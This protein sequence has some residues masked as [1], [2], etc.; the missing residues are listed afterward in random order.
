MTGGQP[1]RGQAGQTRPL[2]LWPTERP[3]PSALTSD[4][5]QLNEVALR[6]FRGQLADSWVPHHME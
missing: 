1:G 3:V 6:F 2:A 5:A 4:V